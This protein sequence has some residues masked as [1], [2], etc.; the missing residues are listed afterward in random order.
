MRPARS[1]ICA[2]FCGETSLQARTS[3]PPWHHV[4]FW[5]A[6]HAHCCGRPPQHPPPGPCPYKRGAA[7]TLQQ[8]RQLRRGCQCMVGRAAACGAA[9]AAAG[10]RSHHT[11]AGDFTTVVA[12][13]PKVGGMLGAVR[14]SKQRL[15]VFHQMWL[16]P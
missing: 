14:C 13:V 4:H 2:R 11:A 16:A 12:H 15:T 10:A 8:P 1:D 5:H 6:V 9:E 3:I 7:A